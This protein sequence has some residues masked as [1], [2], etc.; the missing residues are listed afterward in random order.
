MLKFNNSP[1]GYFLFSFL[2]C[3]VLIFGMSQNAISQEEKDFL[4]GCSASIKECKLP[5][6]F[7]GQAKSCQCFACKYG[8]QKQYVICT[9]NV[10]TAIL[11]HQRAGKSIEVF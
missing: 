4:D 6:K 2:F 1:V 8:T 5:V 11:L 9:D 7:M 3:L 10:D